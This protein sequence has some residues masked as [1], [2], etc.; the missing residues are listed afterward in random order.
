[1]EKG[2]KEFQRLFE[3]EAG[4]IMRDA[5][6]RVS[7]SLVRRTPV[8]EG[9]AVANWE[10]GVN[11]IPTD[12]DRV[13]DPKK[14]ATRARLRETVAA[15]NYGDYV[16]FVNFDEVAARLEFGYSSQAPQGMVRLTARK[17]R[18]FVR[19]AGRAAQNRVR[20]QVIES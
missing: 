2:V 13:N 7:N 14:R 16:A 19:G 11:R 6:T 20:K 15:V 12:V 9:E 4:A 18:G 17:W 8:D 3:A 5:T 1:M 10:A